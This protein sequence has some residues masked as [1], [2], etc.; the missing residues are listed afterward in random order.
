MAKLLTEDQFKAQLRMLTD[1]ELARVADLIRFEM[2]R[3]DV[4]EHGIR[5]GNWCEACNAKYRK[6]NNL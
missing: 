2:D 3:R 6:E 4:C 5:T 1:D